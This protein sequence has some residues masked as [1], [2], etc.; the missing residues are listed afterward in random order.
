MLSGL[1]SLKGK[2]FLA[3]FLLSTM[4]TLAISYVLFIHMRTDHLTTLKREVVF[5]ADLAATQELGRRIARQVAA[6]FD[7]AADQQAV[8]RLK[9][10]MDRSGVGIDAICVWRVASTGGY[11]IWG[12][13]RSAGDRGEAPSLH[14]D[15]LPTALAEPVAVDISKG[16]LEFAVY[17]PLRDDSGKTV[18]LLGLFING[19]SV[20][21]D[22][23]HFA[24]LVAKT[25]SLMII[26]LG[27]ISWWLAQGFTYRLSRL[28]HAIDEMTAGNLNIA[29]S[30]EGKDEVSILANQLNLLASRI[31]GERETMLL[32]AIESLVTALEA[33]DVYT[34]GHSSQVSAI[35]GSIARNIGLSEE[36]LFTV[37]ISALL[38]DIGKIGVPDQILNKVGRLDEEE[39]R[40]IEQHPTI[41]ARILTG[42]PALKQVAE[43]VR[44]HHARWDGKGYPETLCGEEI[45]LVARII[46][47]ADTYQAMTSDRPYRKRLEHEVALLEIMRCAGTQFDPAI[48][49]AFAALRGENR[50]AQISADVTLAQAH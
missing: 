11:T 32:A 33:K 34:Y 8:Q 27:M 50:A 35:A 48:V 2:L 47:V 12:E 41:G 9:L 22:I 30:I 49:T 19:Q 17:A 25:V 1:F 39:R 20:L 45:P 38:H 43:I 26:L 42:I 28:N 16:S 13:A 31:A 40:L 4:I 36:D 10:M 46:A 37:R 14:Q 23:R 3:F 24:V 7:G 5:R 6:D 44:H 18:A 15:A 29:L 21:N